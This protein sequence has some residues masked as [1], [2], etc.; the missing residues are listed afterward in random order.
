MTHNPGGY[1]IAP[2]GKERIGEVSSVVFTNGA[3]ARDHRTPNGCL[4]EHACRPTA[5][6]SLRKS[7]SEI[8]SR[9]PAISLDY[10]A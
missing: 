1:L 4:D 5:Q 2:E 3:I 8:D 7:T 9:E 10:S 6:R